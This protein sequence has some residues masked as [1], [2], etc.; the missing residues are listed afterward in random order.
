MTNKQKK[1]IKLIEWFIPSNYDGKAHGETLLPEG[2]MTAEDGFF[3]FTDKGKMPESVDN[4]RRFNQLLWGHRW[5]TTHEKMYR[6]GMLEATFF[7]FEL[8]GTPA[9][10]FGWDIWNNLS[11]DEKRQIG[12]LVEIQYRLMHG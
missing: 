6:E 2:K 4:P 11:E 12:L 8:E 5:M 7:P 9:E 1:I 3:Q 10:K